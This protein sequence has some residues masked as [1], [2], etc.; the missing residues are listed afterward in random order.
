[1]KYELP[2]DAVAIVLTRDHDALS[3][4]EVEMKADRFNIDKGYK[5]AL[6]NWREASEETC[7]VLARLWGSQLRRNRKTMFG[8]FGVASE[9]TPHVGGGS[10]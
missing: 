3:P 7:N 10:A 9:E 2:P 8:C 5:D 1:M 4:R 6:G